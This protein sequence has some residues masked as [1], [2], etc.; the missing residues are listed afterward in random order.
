MKKVW[1]TTRK[2][3]PGQYVGWYDDQGK[4]RERY[5]NPSCKKYVKTFQTRKFAELNSDIRPIGSTITALW[6]TIKK[7]YLEEKKNVD[8]LA[9]SSIAE[10]RNTLSNFEAAVDP[11][12][13][14]H[15]SKKDVDAFVR[16]L[17]NKRISNNTINKHLRNLKAV[18]AWAK[19]RNYMQDIEIKKVKADDKLIRILN[20]SE[21]RTLLDVC[22]N[23]EQWRMRILM[24]LCTG[25]RRSDLDN[26]KIRNIDIERKTITTRNKKTGKVTGQLP[27]P[28]EL[29][30]HIHKFLGDHV[31]DKQ[32]RFFR[33]HHSKKWERL[34][35]RAGLDDITFHDLRKTYS[36]LL[37]DA[38][39]PIAT[40]QEMLSHSSI[41]TTMKHYITTGDTA[42]R[43]G[44]NK[45]GVKDW[46]I[47][48]APSPEGHPRTH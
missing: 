38:G 45:L 25:L 2:G 35:H 41:Q 20:H 17:R 6:E 10:I 4:R 44:V 1:I 37:A 18:F 12:K 22:G 8:G 9:P 19:K 47:A 34:R 28:E 3:I 39:T 48:Q 14:E 7:D 15:I 13:T 42:A 23:D 36:S 31:R 33:Y 26:L 32:T 27:L 29:M 30:P 11:Y 43:R 46:L 40:V 21:I 16:F 5:F 24:A